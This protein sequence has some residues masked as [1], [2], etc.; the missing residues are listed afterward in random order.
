MPD[1]RQARWKGKTDVTP[2]RAARQCRQIPFR[3]S[4]SNLRCFSANELLRH[5]AEYQRHVKET[6]RRG[7]VN[8][9]S[10]LYW[11]LQPVNVETLMEIDYMVMLDDTNYV[12]SEGTGLPDWLNKL[13][14]EQGNQQ[15]RQ[16]KNTNS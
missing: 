9:K 3:R 6:Q 1:M 15:Q 8:L 7:P 16:E 5:L 4:I 12:G 10:S 13:A 11:S 14:K 2:L